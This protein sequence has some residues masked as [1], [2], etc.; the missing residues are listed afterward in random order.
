MSFDVNA[1][2]GMLQLADSAYPAGGFAFSWGVEGLAA[3]G[4]LNSIE[5]LDHVIE[6]QLSY[7]WHTLDRILLRS[8]FKCENVDQVSFED[9]RAEAVTAS[10]EMRQGSRRAGRALLGVSVKLG[11]AT[12]QL[13][14]EKVARDERLGHLPI[15]Q[16]I[17]SRDAG[18]KL[19]ASELIS[20]WTLI[21]GLTSAAV[22][23]GVIGHVD[24][25]NCQTKARNVLSRL[26]ACR[27]PD[28][29]IPFTFTP[30]IDIAVARGPHRDVRMFST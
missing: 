4:Q 13:Y 18:L 17:V 20:G 1:V 8:V 30:L 21:T 28:D 10:L 14:R 23:L 15:V 3:D 7:R 22:R 26:F 24:A 25:Q 9:L 11:G 5:Q 6:D 29:A 19:D 27:P 12:A 2:L 16:A